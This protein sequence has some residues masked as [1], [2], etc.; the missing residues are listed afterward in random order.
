MPQ[1]GFDQSSIC[2]NLHEVWDLLQKVCGSPDS[3]ELLGSI[4]IEINGSGEG[5]SFKQKRLG[6][7]KRIACES[8][9]ENQNS[10]RDADGMNY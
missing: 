9:L 5:D 7:A 4:A 3:L 10:S 2:L 6:V 1:N 8:F